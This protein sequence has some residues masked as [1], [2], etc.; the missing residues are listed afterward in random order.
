MI[1]HK[2]LF[3][4]HF[5]IGLRQMTEDQI[6]LPP[7]YDSVG[8]PLNGTTAATSGAIESSRICSDGK[9]WAADAYEVGQAAALA[10]ASHKLSLTPP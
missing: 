9:F 10:S 7:W 4:S 6:Y 2:L 1:G 8:G 5:L 3:V